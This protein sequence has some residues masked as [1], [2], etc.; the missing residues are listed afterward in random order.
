MQYFAESSLR[1][2]PPPDASVLFIVECCPLPLPSPP[3][4]IMNLAARKVRVDLATEAWNLM[5]R[6]KYPPTASNYNAMLQTL[7][8][9]RRDRSALLALNVRRDGR[10]AWTGPEQGR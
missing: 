8:A 1:S 5:D 3:S 2:R 6:F 9:D 7:I 4:Q 10:Q